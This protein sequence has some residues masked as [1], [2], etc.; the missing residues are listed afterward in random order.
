MGLKN[1]FSEAKGGPSIPW[2]EQQS[3]RLQ[4]PAPGTVSPPYA[5]FYHRDEDDDDYGENNH[6]EADNNHA[7]ESLEDICQGLHRSMP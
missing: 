2:S 5:S 4:S 1:H 6:K 3:A 7:T